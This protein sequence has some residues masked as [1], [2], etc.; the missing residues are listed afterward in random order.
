MTALGVRSAVSKMSWIGRLSLQQRKSRARAQGTEPLI[1][2]DRF[3]FQFSAAVDAAVG[4]MVFAG[5]CDSARSS[6]GPVCRLKLSA[7]LIKPT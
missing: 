3:Q 1:S 5:V 4:T 7:Q 2:R 6:I